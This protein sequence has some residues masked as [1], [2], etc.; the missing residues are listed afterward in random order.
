MNNIKIMI[1]IL[2]FQKLHHI[3]S[4]RYNKD[5]VTAICKMIAD[6]GM[7][8]PNFKRNINLISY[9]QPKNTSDW[10]YVEWLKTL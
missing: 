5:E 3:L 6:D 7:Q 4:I 8:M 1:N 2:E 10:K 9:Q